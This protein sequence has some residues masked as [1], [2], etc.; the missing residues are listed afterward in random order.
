MPKESVHKKLERVR[1]PRVNITYEVETGGAMEVRELPFVMGVLA[2]FSGQP[3]TELP[4]LKDRKFIECT[5]D[6]F[7]EVL[8]KM[9]PH[10]HLTVANKLSDDPNAGKIAV[11]LTFESMDDFSPD[12]VAPQVEPLKKLLD[13]R[14]QLADLRGKIQSNEKLEE[15]LQATLSDEEKRKKLK[16]ELEAGAASAG[17]KDG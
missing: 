17:G 15:L 13:M 4:K 1:P 5:L 12:R 11:D 9:Q 14:S 3:T 8:G 16:S 10:L 7:D 2:D 6:N